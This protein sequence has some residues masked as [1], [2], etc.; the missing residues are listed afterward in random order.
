MSALQ[1]EHIPP[2][3]KLVDDRDEEE[4]IRQVRESG[5]GATSFMPV[6]HKIAWPGWEDAAVPGDKLGTYLRDFRHLLD[7]Y[8]LDGSLYGHFGQGWST[9]ARI[10]TWSPETVSRSSARYRGRRRPG[11]PIWRLVLGRARRWPGARR[12][13]RQDVRARVGPG[14]SGVQVHLGIA[15]TNPGKVVD[16]YPLDSNLR[17][18]THFDPPVQRTHFEFIE[19]QSSFRGGAALRRRWH[20]HCHHKDGRRAGRAA[21]RRRRLHRARFGLLRHGGCLRLPGAGEH[22]DV[23]I[24]AG[25]RVLLPQVRKAPRE[26]LI[27]ADGFSCREQ[28]RAAHRSARASPGRASA[29]GL[30]HNG[31]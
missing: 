27:V 13:P 4:R 31:R 5:L 16:A 2:S 24:K 9:L 18:G 8:S 22:Y 11:A 15:W 26:E 20:G 14:L 10:S 3:M 29:N 12:A 17:L 25:E 1:I 28:N 19:D 30:L 21:A 7:Q 23:S 6:S